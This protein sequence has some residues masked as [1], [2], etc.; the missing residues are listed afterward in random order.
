MS[1]EEFVIHVGRS[2]DRSGDENDRFTASPERLTHLVPFKRRAISSAI[3]VRSRHVATLYF[4]PPPFAVAHGYIILPAIK[5]SAMRSLGRP[6]LDS[7]TSLAPS[8]RS[9]GAV[10]AFRPDRRRLPCPQQSI[11]VGAFADLT[12][13]RGNERK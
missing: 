8:P 10:K 6:L 4:Q 9:V 5:R 1:T 7:Q 13:E 11:E 12:A 3:F 2:Q